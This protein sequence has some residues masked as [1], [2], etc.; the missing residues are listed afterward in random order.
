[1]GGAL[2]AQANMSSMRMSVIRSCMAN[3]MLIGLKVNNYQIVE[4]L[5]LGCWME[6]V[7]VVRGS[8]S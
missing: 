4:G 2:W 8:Y 3:S 5:G 7:M 6:I 1:M